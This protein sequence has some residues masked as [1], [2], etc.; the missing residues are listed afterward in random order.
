MTAG[1]ISVRWANE[2]HRFLAGIEVTLTAGGSAVPPVQGSGKSGKP[3]LGLY[4]FDVDPLGGT[5][6][7]LTVRVPAPGAREGRPKV[8]EPLVELTQRFHIEG[9]ATPVPES[10]A[11][12][13]H[14]RVRPMTGTGAG[15]AGLVGLELDLSFIDVTAYLLATRAEA[16]ACCFFRSVDDHTEEVGGK[17]AFLPRDFGDCRVRLFQHTAGEPGVFAV[18]VSPG[19]DGSERGVDGVLFQKPSEGSGYADVDDV[20]LFSL[21]RYITSFGDGTVWD[22]C[23]L[24]EDY[25]KVEDDGWFGYYHPTVSDE[26]PRRIA[27]LPSEKP[28]RGW[29]L[30]PR[31]RFA[32]QIGRSG[33]KVVF[34]MPIANGSNFGVTGGSH[35]RARWR[36]VL[37]C[38]QGEGLVGDDT[39]AEVTLRK[40]AVGGFSAGGQVAFSAFQLNRDEIDEVWMFDP[41]GIE[42]N[43]SLVAEW[44]TGDRRARFIAGSTFRFADAHRAELKDDPPAEPTNTIPERPGPATVWPRH[45]T[46]FRRSE[47]YARASAWAEKKGSWVPVARK[48]DTIAEA[49]VRAKGAVITTPAER[50]PSVRTGFREVSMEPDGDADEDA[51]HVVAILPNQTP[52]SI[53]A[54]PFANSTDVAERLMFVTDTPVQTSREF[55]ELVELLERGTGSLLHQWVAFGGQSVGDTED[56]ERWS[57]YLELCLRFSTFED[58]T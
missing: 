24:A 36:S 13:W 15:K 54:L 10:P 37:A 47:V 16:V 34:L 40:L 2:T 41:I 26:P 42:A 9:D 44:C 3:R 23:N 58:R 7:E 11:T 14:P 31:C 32:Q 5:S 49:E 45:S 52:T 25:G 8:E 12:G 20:D 21:S 17:R 39:R 33:K 43:F 22:D 53:R 6:F 46:F 30:V 57:G 29:S 19:F 35:L 56:P 27:D 50:R 1:R 28:D 55:G 4:K 51:L 18:L 48:L 38:L